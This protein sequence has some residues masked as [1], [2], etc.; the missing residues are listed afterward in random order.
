MDKNFFLHIKCFFFFFL[1]VP[2]HG[3]E[4]DGGSDESIGSTDRRA[5]EAISNASI[6]P[7]IYYI[8]DTY[9]YLYVSSLFKGVW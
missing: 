2:T 8:G 3:S 5:A 4:I 7:N 6:N 1:G 9:I